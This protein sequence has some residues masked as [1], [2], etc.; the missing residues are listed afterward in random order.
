MS[1]MLVSVGRAKLILLVAGILLALVGVMA[2]PS[3]PVGPDGLPVSPEGLTSVFVAVAS[4][5]AFTRQGV[6][7]ICVGV[8]CIALGALLPSGPE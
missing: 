5:G 2:L 6:V 4:T 3:T 8:G 1:G 7:L